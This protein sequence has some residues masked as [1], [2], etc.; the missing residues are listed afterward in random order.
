MDEDKKMCGRLAQLTLF[1]GTFNIYMYRQVI[2]RYRPV[3]KKKRQILPV[4]RVGLL[5]IELMPPYGD[6][7]F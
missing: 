3:I 4:K 6:W 1:S 5:V 2:I 7:D